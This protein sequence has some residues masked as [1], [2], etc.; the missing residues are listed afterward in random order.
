MALPGSAASSRGVEGFEGFA[1]N[2]VADDS[3]AEP[4]GGE[5]SAEEVWALVQHQAIASS[6]P[7][8]TIL[9]A[10]GRT[11]V[12]ATT[13][14]PAR[15]IGLVTFTQ[16]GLNFFC[17]G[18]LINKNTVATAGQC[19]YGDGGLGG[20]R[21]WSTNVRFYPGRNG[22]TSPYGSCAARNLY[23]VTGWTVNANE[24]Y[25]YGAI[26]LNC[27]IGNTTGWFGFWWQSTSLNG[28]GETVAGYPGD[29]PFG[30]QWKAAGS[31]GA[32]ETL[33]VF[34]NNDTAAGQSG[35]PVYQPARSG[36]YCS[37]AC[38]LA[39]HAYG[40]HGSGNHATRNHGTRITQSVFNN[41]VYWRNLP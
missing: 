35:S 29:K 8:Q 1:A 28:T 30:Q 38:A 36:P 34:Y 11:R 27:T 13:T 22:S 24:R 10:D 18:W 33:Q 6:I 41:L 14:F 21:V 23:S 15:A 12:S 25:D 7:T 39:I 4:V 9:G 37:G 20:A 2:G 40:L 31:V 19:L 16:R 26:K 3:Y 5:Q 32:T 17:S